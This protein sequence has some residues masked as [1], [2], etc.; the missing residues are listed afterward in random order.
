MFM[1]SL[2]PIIILLALATTM[3]TL[4][5]QKEDLSAELEVAAEAQISLSDGNTPLWLNANKYGLS[6]LKEVNGYLRVS[7]LRPASADSLRKWRWGY[8][9]D[10]VVAGGYTSVFVVQQAYAELGIH[11]GLLTVGSKELPLVLKN[12]SLSSGSQTLGKNARPIP[13][14]RIALED[15]WTIPGL[16]HWVHLKGH[17]AYGWYTDSRWQRHFTEG[18][19]NQY[20][21]GVAYHS[22]AAYF[23]VGESDELRHFSLEFGAEMACQ[24]GGKLHQRNAD[25]TETVTKLK[26]GFT[27]YV[28]ALFF[29]GQDSRDDLYGNQE[30]NHLG[31]WLLRLNYVGDTWAAS[32]Y[33]DHYFEDFSQMFFLTYDGYGTGDDW[34]K[35]EDN[36]YYRFP[37]KDFMVGAEV[38]LKK[39]P[40][41]NNIVVEY[42]YTKYQ[43]GP[44]NHDRTSNISDH[45]DG[46]DNYY[47]HASYGAYQH[48]GQVLGNP[49]YLSPIYNEDGRISVMNNRFKAIHVGL[50]GAPLAHLSYRLLATYQA[51]WGTYDDP[52]TH[53]QTNFSMLFE[54][55]YAFLNTWAAR[56]SIGF[57]KGEIM[58]NNFG[59]QLTLRKTLWHGPTRKQHPNDK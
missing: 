8:G 26:G 43:S 9:A 28:H 19:T 11:H 38:N 49:L 18:T 48:W 1:M 59:V 54:G 24:F 58:G 36:R 6:S 31:S 16:H 34:Q 51:G 37:L 5:Q 14:V 13:Q 32:L 25:G 21:T 17:I 42:L 52:Y 4:A 40:Y 41:L 44:Y 55:S 22:K 56:C 27:S 35:R 20:T 47:N 30:G 50:G 3:H 33:A 57:D 46:V 12:D 29:G 7:A 45:V 39:F 2:R 53:R 10:L 23:K 15:Y